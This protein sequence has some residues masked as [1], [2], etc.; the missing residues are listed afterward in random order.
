MGF[1][2]VS[3]MSDWVVGVRVWVER[4]GQA[5]LGQGRL[6]LLEEIDRCRSISAAARQ[7]GM[8]YR[9][10]WVLVQGINRAAGEPL[11]E[12]ATGGHHGGGARL[13]PHGR[14][15]VT[16]FRDL[17]DQLRRTAAG[18][19]P[20][21]LPEF[22]RT[23]VH[24]AAAVSMEEVLGQLLTD[25]ALR[26]PSVR[27]R[28]VFGASD[29]LADQLLGGAPADLFLT[30]DPAQLDRLAGAGIV[31]PGAPTLLAENGLVAIGQVDRGLPVRKPA[32]LLGPNVTRL[33]L[34]VPSCPLGGYTRAYL[35]GRGLYEPLLARAVLVENARAAVAA[36]QTGQADAGL[37]YSSATASA[38]G[39]QVLFRVRG[40][41]E[42][43]R[44]VG[45]V[46][47]RG[48]QGEQARRLLEFLGSKPAV[49][50]FR[51][52]GFLPVRDRGSRRRTDEAPG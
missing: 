2:E 48:H 17:Q 31:E 5:V 42:P 39:C 8:S 49:R 35:V 50:R 38:P 34:A 10:A 26:Q 14:L 6:E 16:V 20:R 1:E 27:V 24:V 19:L 28:A 30:A 41:P 43:I 13:T 11:V 23:S 52:C 12:A 32:D 7:V 21:L 18:L 40:M 25:Y 22:A 9:H 15:A 3:W 44:Y 36:V 46:V 45:A 51:S 33:A 29:E 47:R 4:A 37:V